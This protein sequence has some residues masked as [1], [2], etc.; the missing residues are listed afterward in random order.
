LGIQPGL[1]VGQFLELGLRKIFFNILGKRRHQKTYADA[2]IISEKHPDPAA[3]SASL[4]CAT[5]FTQAA[6]TFYQVSLALQYASLHRKQS[7]I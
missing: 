5:D 1:Q 6:R 2:R 4:R 3:F 7:I